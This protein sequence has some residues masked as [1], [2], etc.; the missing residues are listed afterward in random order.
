MRT[1][2]RPMYSLSTEQADQPTISNRASG[3]F[4]L[5]IGYSLVRR[6]FAADAPGYHPIDATNVINGAWGRWSSVTK[7]YKDVSMPTGTVLIEA[8]GLI[9]A[10][11]GA[12]RDEQERNHLNRP[13]RCLSE[14][15][16][17]ERS[18][19]CRLD[20]P[21]LSSRSIISR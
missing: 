18:N 16:I 20:R 6:R 17:R 3:T 5:I 19:C 7:G 21:E 11:R 2:G 13:I 9:F 4:L 10:I 1:S 8:V 12:S 15:N 14:R